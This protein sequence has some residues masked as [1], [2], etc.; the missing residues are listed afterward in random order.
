MQAVGMFG[1]MLKT[2]DLYLA[3]PEIFDLVVDKLQTSDPITAIDAII[4]DFENMSFATYPIKSEK[5]NNTALNFLG[6]CRGMEILQNVFEYANAWALNIDKKEKV[7][8]EKFA[9]IL[10]D[11]WDAESF[12]NYEQSFRYLAMNRNFWFIFLLVTKFGVIEIPF[13]PTELYRFTRKHKGR[14]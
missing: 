5:N 13:L 14:K 8:E 2:K 3:A 6:I 9:L 1:Y 12:S 10:T 4:A 7:D 11:K